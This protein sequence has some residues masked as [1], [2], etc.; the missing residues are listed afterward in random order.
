MMVM[1]EAQKQARYKYAK[2]ALKRIPLDVP[3]EEYERIKEAADRTGATVNGFIKTAIREKIE[4]D[5][6]PE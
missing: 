5:S 4:R 3:K 6:Q 1:T 2:K